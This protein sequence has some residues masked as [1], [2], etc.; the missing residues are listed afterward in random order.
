[1]AD[2]LPTLEE[3]RQRRSGLDSCQVCGADI[4]MMV[5]RGTGICSEN[6]EKESKRATES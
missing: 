1:M 5:R 6:C 3:V 2:R 4:K